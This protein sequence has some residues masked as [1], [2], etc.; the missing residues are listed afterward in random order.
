[1]G[2]SH[3]RLSSL[4]A[5]LDEAALTSASYDSEWSIGQV[6][7]HLGSQAEIFAG[8]LN[9]ALAGEPA[10]GP[11]S[12]PPIWDRW[13]ARSPLQ[14]RDDSTAANEAL[15]QAVEGL[16]PSQVESFQLAMFGNTL[17]LAGFVRMRLGEHAVHTWDV[18]VALDPGATVAADAVALLLPGLDQVARRSGRASEEPF[19][20]EVVTTDPDSAVLVTVTDTVALHP[21]PAD[22]TVDGTITL[23]AEAFLRLVYGRLDPE[24]TPDVQES[25]ARGV[26][27][28]RRTFPGF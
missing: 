1:M 12:F 14:W 10:P 3:D 9:S 13:N 27:D 23:P 22:S 11:E 26:A 2:N 21:A 19:V 24:H 7:S 25:G 17:D 16:D 6:L 8:F 18:A 15:V 4:V 5:D 20:V 28:L